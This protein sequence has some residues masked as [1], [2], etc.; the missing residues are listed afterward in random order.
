MKNKS[1]Q[2]HATAHTLVFVGPYSSVNSIVLTFR[3]AHMPDTILMKLNSLVSCPFHSAMEPHFWCYMIITMSSFRRSFFC[4]LPCIVTPPPSPCHHII[5][6]LLCCIFPLS[7]FQSPT[8]FAFPFLPI[9]LYPFLPHFELKQGTH[10]PWGK[11]KCNSPI[12]AHPRTSV[13]H[14]S[15]N[16]SSKHRYVD[17]WF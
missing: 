4:P 13:R 15:S 6:S 12:V 2:L 11:Y 3:A 7:S 5:M 10:S 8:S 17:V 16:S 1:T 14:I 9:A